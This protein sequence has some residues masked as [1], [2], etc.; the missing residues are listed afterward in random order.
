MNNT[1][2]IT[3][4]LF[5][6]GGDDRRLAK[7]E[8]IHPIP[9]GTSYN[10]YVLLDE[11]TVLFDTAD[12]E[13]ARDFEE[14]IKYVL[15]GRNLD[16]IVINHIEPDHAASL[17]MIAKDYPE[18]KII[19]TA[20]AK[21]LIDQFGFLNDEE[22]ITVKEGEE[23]STGEHTLKFIMAPMVHW[24]EVMVTYMDGIL[25]SA[26]A[27]GAFG[28]VNGKIFADERKALHGTFAEYYRRYYTNIVGK[29]GPQVLNLLKKA[30][31]LDIKMICPL[32]GPVF[33]TEENIKWA[34]EKYKKWAAYE[35]EEKGA[36]IVYASMYGGTKAAA[37]HIA[38]KL[39]ENGV[40]NYELYDV[41]SIDASYLISSAFKY[42][43]IVLCS[44]TY[45]MKVFPPMQYFVDEMRNLNLQNRTFAVVE[46]GS[47]APQ[48]KKLIVDDI[49][50]M[51]GSRTL[52][53]ACSIKSNG[54]SAN[55]DQ[56]KC[57][58]DV[59]A[60]DIKNQ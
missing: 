11:K 9:E 47:W 56:L 37:E 6:V 60:E 49:E 39:C 36:L 26:D 54:T 42:S 40:T 12:W 50:K 44:V 52:E 16:Y 33:R 38:I 18:A 14:N 21:N 24:P 25:F 55:Q 29:Y 34:V 15:D 48:A 23:L 41:S 17:G 31:A 4:N 35:P 3:D 58:A 10:S 7:F 8:N 53:G 43:H 32:H 51:K 13:V 30:S 28:A 59:I 46:N 27:F 2:M 45:N 57:L 20:K 1:R 5:W 19:C 22:I